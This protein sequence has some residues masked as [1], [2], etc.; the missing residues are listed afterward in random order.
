MNTKGVRILIAEGNTLLLM[1][2]SECLRQDGYEVF[3]AEDGTQALHLLD[4]P[5]DIDL[6]ITS[7]GLD[8][9]DGMEVARKARTHGEPVPVIFA[10]GRSDLPSAHAHPPA[11]SH[12]I[13]KPFVMADIRAAVA[14]LLRQP[15]S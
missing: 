1:D 3:E 15:K 7:L 6:I 12:R 13:C 5:D 9:A 11:R 8:G 10:S 14:D 4:H 2:L